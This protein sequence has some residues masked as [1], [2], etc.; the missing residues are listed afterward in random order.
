MLQEAIGATAGRLPIRQLAGAPE[1]PARH[2]AVR[3]PARTTFFEILAGRQRAL[4]E[5]ERETLPDAVV[6][7]R[8]HIGTAEAKNQQHLHGPSADATDGRE[9]GDERR[10]EER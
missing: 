10:S 1:V 3:L 4:P 7:Q 9:T 8:Q 6:V 5:R 2:R